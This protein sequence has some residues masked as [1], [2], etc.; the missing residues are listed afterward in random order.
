MLGI[1]EPENWNPNI[2]FSIKIKVYKHAQSPSICLSQTLG[3]VPDHFQICGSAVFFSFFSRMLQMQSVGLCDLIL[4][5]LL[6]HLPTIVDRCLLHCCLTPTWVCVCFLSAACTS[7]P[8][9]T[10]I[11][12]R[13]MSTIAGS[14]WLEDLMRASARVCECLRMCVCDSDGPASPTDDWLTDE[15]RRPPTHAGTGG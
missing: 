3:N 12:N 6:Q 5:Y 9:S 1:K 14:R 8:S 7:C 13:I 15:H 4:F 10:L 11:Q 2:F